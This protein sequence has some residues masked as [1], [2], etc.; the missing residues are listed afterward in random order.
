MVERGPE[1]RRGRRI[2]LEA[3]LLM[4]HVE[5]K[6]PR[7]IT[8]LSTKNVSLAGVYFE[9]DGDGSSYAVNQVVMTSVAIPES[10]RRD[11]PF[12]RLAGTSRVVRVTELPQADADDKK[13][14]GV[15]LEFSDDLITLTATPPRG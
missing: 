1:R 10:Q 6:S 4:W 11:F 12:T 2:N 13:R 9:T 8:E 14:F 15:A 3:P 7:P 5:A